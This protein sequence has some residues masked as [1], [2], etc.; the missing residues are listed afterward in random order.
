ML[1]ATSHRRHIVRINV[2]LLEHEFGGSWEG[3]NNAIFSRP[4]PTQI[5]EFER[6]PIRCIIGMDGCKRVGTL[7]IVS[8]TSFEMIH[9]FQNGIWRWAWSMD[10]Y[11]NNRAAKWMERSPWSLGPSPSDPGPTHGFDIKK[12]C[13]T[14]VKG[15]CCEHSCLEDI[16]S[17]VND[18]CWIYG[19]MHNAVHLSAWIIVSQWW[20]T[21]PPP[22]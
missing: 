15:A 18:M 12:Q 8:G 7:S 14:L 20:S 11:T 21:S 3:G 5:V 1:A 10:A 19:N 2:F 13:M 22:P 6:S 4:W 9:H 17:L 16:T